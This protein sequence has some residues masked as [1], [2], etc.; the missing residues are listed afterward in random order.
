[1]RQM[2]LKYFFLGQIGQTYFLTM[3]SC[4]RGKEILLVSG[5]TVFHLQVLLFLFRNAFQLI[6]ATSVKRFSD[7]SFST[8]RNTAPEKHVSGPVKA[9]IQCGGLIQSAYILR[10]R[11]GI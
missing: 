10:M 2:D 4:E 9:E 8:F 6:L 5:H 11:H 1:M 3:S 7:Y